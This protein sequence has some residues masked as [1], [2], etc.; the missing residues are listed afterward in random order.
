M[1]SIINKFKEKY[2]V[3]KK[4]FGLLKPADVDH[5]KAILSE[6]RVL[7]EESDVLPYNIDWIKNCR[8]TW[9]LEWTFWK[10]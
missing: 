5:F 6:D 2:G 3:K 10:L 8:G 4:T 9:D 7:T 1:F